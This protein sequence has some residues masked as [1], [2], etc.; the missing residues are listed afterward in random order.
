VKFGIAFA[1]IAG[2]AGPAGA[3]AMGRAAEAS[4]FESVWTVEHVLIP[5]GYESTYPY[6]ASG[7]MPAPD[8]MDLPDPIVWLTW[9]AAHTTTLRLATGVLVLP[10][11]NP[12][13]LAKEVATLDSLSGGRV[14]LGVGAGWLREEFDALSVPF[15]GRGRRLE[16]YAAAMRGLWSGAE[17]DYDDDFVHFSRA[18]SRPNPAAGSVPIHIGG[19]SDISARRAGRMGD[20]YFPGDHSDLPRLLE[21]LR[22][23]ADEAG[24]D[25]ASIEVTVTGAST[26]GS[27]GVAEVERLAELGVDRIVIP[28]LTFDP[29]GLDEALGAYADRVIARF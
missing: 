16:S 28:P 17:T 12:A 1:N 3:V 9:V 11:R 29:A 2:F 6:D 18:V 24:R 20:G 14:I 26:L 4:G 25:P 7:R 21:L 27:E 8:H 23:S 19:H 5:A 10:Q 15:D 13:V 22:R